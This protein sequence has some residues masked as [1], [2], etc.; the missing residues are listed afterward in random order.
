MT[1]TLRAFLAFFLGFAYLAKPGES[2]GVDLGLLDG[3]KY[4][5]AT[6]PSGGRIVYMKEGQP[7]LRDLIVGKHESL[8]AIAIDQTN[9]RLYVA[10][11]A[12]QTIFW[13]QLV[14]LPDGR[15]TTD[16]RKN[17]AII[18]VEAQSLECDGSGNLYVG[19]KAITAVTPSMPA[20]P[21]S[22]MKFT[23]YQLLTGD[24][25]I[26]AIEGIWNVA[27]S[28]SPPKMWSPSSIVTDG[29]RLI[30]GNGNQGGTHGAIVEAPVSPPDTDPVNSIKVHVDQGEK[31][32]SVAL[33]PE[34]LFYSTENGIF[35][36]PLYKKEQGCGRPVDNDKK[37]LNPV[38]LSLKNGGSG[39]GPPP[40]CRRISSDIA[41]TKG[42]VWDGDGTVYTLD[43]EKGIY[44]FPSG[45]IE[46]HKVEEVLSFE[47]LV[48][49][50][51]LQVSSAL[52]KTMPSVTSIVLALAAI[53]LQ[54]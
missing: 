16:G 2:G 7:V 30:W 43:P 44:S 23:W 9:A 14:A 33:T 40:P 10:D 34:F 51:L 29:F 21:V 45:N 12:V 41:N 38:K 25:N 3:T 54:K 22:I 13:Y 5:V 50:D 8:G 31:V 46:E 11:N 28:G 47:G 27:N 20:P 4:F 39:G 1:F 19:G 49:M 26:L 37:K 35:G 24:P 18:T 42:M 32:G 53:L 6:H 36:T 48:D 15:L 52:M 17:T